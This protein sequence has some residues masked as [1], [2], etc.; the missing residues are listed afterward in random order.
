[1]GLPLGGV[2]TI[3]DRLTSAGW[4]RRTQACLAPPAASSGIVKRRELKN[5]RSMHDRGAKLDGPPRLIL[6]PCSTASRP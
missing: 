1:M 5:M 2:A 3:A 4:A 6:P